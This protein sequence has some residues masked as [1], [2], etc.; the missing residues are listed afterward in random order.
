MNLEND[1]R[2]LLDE[3]DVLRHPCDL[4]LI[5]FFARHPR[6]LLA[7]EQ[8]A[9]FLGYGVKE[10]A[11]SL[12]LLLDAGFL[13]RTPN[14]RHVARMYVFS[15]DA[16]G[17]GW[18]PALVRLAATRNGRLELIWAIRERSSGTAGGPSG[19]DKRGHRPAPGTLLFPRR[20]AAGGSGER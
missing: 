10:I 14:P 1:A 13:T 12:E 15:V 7:S 3:L 11:D 18:L 4:D 9:A 19:P 17:G 8:L 16:P 5:I 2:R 20:R 6:S